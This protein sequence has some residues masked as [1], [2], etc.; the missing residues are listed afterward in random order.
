MLYSYEFIS[1]NLLTSKQAARVVMN[2][3]FIIIQHILY[4]INS[5]AGNLVGM[6][7]TE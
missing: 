7:A 4:R 3:C 5:Y 6:M 2:D 1:D